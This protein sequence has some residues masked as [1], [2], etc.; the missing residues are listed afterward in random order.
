MVLVVTKHNSKLSQIEPLAV[1]R[2]RACELVASSKLVQRW[3]YWTRHAESPEKGWLQIVRS[4][5]RGTE[6]LID[7]ASLKAAYD[8]YR[9]GDEPPVLPCERRSK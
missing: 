8:R 3:L 9:K 5:G 4:G 7:Y 1:T 2:Q 6:T